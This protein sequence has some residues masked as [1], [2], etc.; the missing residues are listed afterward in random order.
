MSKDHELNQNTVLHEMT[1]DET[2]AY[3]VDLAG[4]HGIQEHL[5]VYYK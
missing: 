5:R 2:K 3:Y 4:K 1:T